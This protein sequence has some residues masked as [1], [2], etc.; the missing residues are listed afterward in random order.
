[1]CAALFRS[2]N[3]RILKLDTIRFCLR[4]FNGGRYFTHYLGPKLKVGQLAKFGQGHCFLY[5]LTVGINN[6]LTKQTV[7]ILMRRL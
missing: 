6:K 2:I 3:A 4:P 5:N 1:M 7:K